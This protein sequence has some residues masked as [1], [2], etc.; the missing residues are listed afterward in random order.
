MIY[1]NPKILVLLLFFLFPTFLMSCGENG[2]DGENEGSQGFS[3]ATFNILHGIRNEDPAAQPYDRFPERLA[4]IRQELIRRHPLAVA[5]QEVV[6]F[7]LPDYPDVLGSLLQSTNA[8]GTSQYEAVF[9][10]L[11][12]WEP[13]INGGG[14]IGQLTLTSLPMSGEPHNTSVSLFRSVLHTR[15]VSPLGPV[16][17]YNVHIE[18]TDEG[19]PAPAVT[20]IENVLDFVENTSGQ[21]RMVVLAGDFN[22]EEDSP[23][24][25]VLEQAGFVDLGAASGLECTVTDRTGC[26]AN[27][28]PLG[29][30]GIRTDERIDYVLLRSKRPVEFQCAPLFNEPFPLGEGG[31][32]W[33]SDHIGLNCTLR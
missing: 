6:L 32:L 12:G 17:L 11:F 8:N 27:T 14:S 33:A 5:L 30:Q 9:G 20:E 29:E 3:I 7:P 13:V 4:L 25:E 18:G 21:D 31:V 1:R 23:V 16:D 24:F 26:T 19:D 22:S 28:I 15:I 10:A 2:T